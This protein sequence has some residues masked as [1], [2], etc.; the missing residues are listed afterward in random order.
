MDTDLRIYIDQPIEPFLFLQI[1]LAKEEIKK[2]TH[3]LEMH[4]LTCI[5]SV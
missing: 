4:N 2:K 3:S 5:K 1:L